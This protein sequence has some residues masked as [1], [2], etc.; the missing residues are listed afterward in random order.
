M[1]LVEAGRV[2]VAIDLTKV[3]WFEGAPDCDPALDHH[4]EYRAQV[5]IQFSKIG[6][7]EARD[8]IKREATR[9]IAHHIYGPITRE[10][11][12][13]VMELR[14]MRPD[15]WPQIERLEKLIRE[16]EGRT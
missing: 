6:P 13:V 7:E 16:M 15:V 8:Y 10:L 1:R 9:S 12:D 14:R 2:P 5:T 4:I 3:G 11:I